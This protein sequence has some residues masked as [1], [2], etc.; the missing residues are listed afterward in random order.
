M[1]NIQNLLVPTFTIK[2]GTGAGSYTTTSTSYVDVDATNQALTVTIPIGFVLVIRASGIVFSTGGFAQ[3]IAVCLADST[4]TL[5]EATLDVLAGA[6]TENYTLDWLIAG[7]GN[8]HTVKLR[9]K[10]S[11]HTVGLDNSSSTRIPVMIFNLTA[12]Q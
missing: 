10:T 11:A 2:K 7:D 12:S 3:E 9:Y 5:V 6:L 1:S 4:T 8:S